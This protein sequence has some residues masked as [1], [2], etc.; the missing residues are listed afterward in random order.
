[1]RGDHRSYNRRLALPAPSALPLSSSAYVCVC[2][3]VH[4]IV[5]GCVCVHGIVLGSGCDCACTCG[6]HL[7]S[8]R[9]LHAMALPARVLSAFARRVCAHACTWAA[10][11]SWACSLS[12]DTYVRIA[13]QHMK[14]LKVGLGVLPQVSF[15]Q[16]FVSLV[17]L[18]RDDVR[19]VAPR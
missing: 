7:C 4:G 11:T 18:A 3:C 17:V 12:H 15:L 6:L 19:D 16:K 2:V 14:K 5:L 8:C 1:M 9:M 13:S 10:Q